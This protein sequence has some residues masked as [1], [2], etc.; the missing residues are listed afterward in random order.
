MADELYPENVTNKLDKYAAAAVA[1]QLNLGEIDSGVIEINAFLRGW[2]NDLILKPSH[3]K[4]FTISLLRG[5]SLLL[6]QPTF[7]C[8]VFRMTTRNTNAIYAVLYS[9]YD[10]SNGTIIHQYI[11]IGPTYH[12]QDGE[13]RH[14]FIAYSHYRA[15]LEFERYSNVSVIAEK[16]VLGEIASSVYIPHVDYFMD[17]KDETVE[18]KLRENISNSRLAVELFVTAWMEDYHRARLGLTENH[19]NSAY[20]KV[21]CEETPTANITYQELIAK[22]GSLGLYQASVYKYVLLS[23]S[24][25]YKPHIGVKIIPIRKQESVDVGNIQ[26]E[27]WRE[28]NAMRGCANLMLNF[29]S[30]TF[31]YVYG[32][33]I[34]KNTDARLFDNQAMYDKYVQSEVADEISTQLE[35]ANSYTTQDG[36][37][38]NH[39]FHKLSDKIKDAAKYG[40][41]AI[42]LTNKAFCM[43]QEHT[44]V[45]LGD[46][47]LNYK[48]MPRKE[49]WIDDFYNDI[50]VFKKQ[51]FE[52]IYGFYCLN[53]RMH[54]VHGDLHLNNATI[55]PLMSYYNNM[56]DISNKEKRIP[57]AH[58]MYVVHGDVFMFPQ[59][60]IVSVIIDLSRA[61]FGSRDSLTESN[62]EV[63]ADTFLRVQ[64]TH[65]LRIMKRN[66]P[67]MMELHGGDIEHLITNNFELFF[68]IFSAVD[69]LN[70]ARRYRLLLDAEE[71]PRPVTH[72]I[73]FLHTVETAAEK[74]FLGKLDEAIT[75]KIKKIEDMPWPNYTLMHEL[76]ADCALTKRNAVTATGKQFIANES[77]YTVVDIFNQNAELRYNVDTMRSHPPYLNTSLLRNVIVP[78]LDK[79][80]PAQAKLADSKIIE[81]NTMMQNDHIEREYALTDALST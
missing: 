29:I 21:V 5:K 32:W 44:Y 1:K 10:E 34:I 35:S 38:I 41:M 56:G 18:A 71:F 54:M 67:E 60:G 2:S 31:P 47:H 76:F 80:E 68:R 43:I 12:S 9:S 22:V 8:S 74:I 61:V 28:W 30:P 36:I 40:D 64:R 6:I 48:F 42:R 11:N 14:R 65:I 19:I 77:D 25:V 46:L 63:F 62:D 78:A 51:I 69:I 16:Y 4:R 53:S 52:F 20:R 45:T 13:Y 26:Y 15:L 70:L 58:I 39:R 27:L 79:K 23:Q 57:N 33:F 7:I 50:S 3:M 49:N 75:G 81:S 24:N 72:M 55:Y 59:T 17:T 37:Y 66:Y 73:E